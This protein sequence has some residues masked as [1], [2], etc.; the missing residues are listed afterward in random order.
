MATI[1]ATRAFFLGARGVTGDGS[2]EAFVDPLASSEL[3]AHRRVTGGDVVLG[4]RIAEE[5]DGPAV[6][7]IVEMA[8][9][10]GEEPLD[11]GGDTLPC[12][13]RPARLGT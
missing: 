5:I 1:S 6:F 4:E 13:G 12:G 2:G 7:H 10:V 8:G 11:L 3:T 9:T